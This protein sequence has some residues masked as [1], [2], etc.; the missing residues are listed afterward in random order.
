MHTSRQ[1]NEVELTDIRQL[2]EPLH[3]I[4][5][6]YLLITHTL[7]IILIQTLHIKVQLSLNYANIGG[8]NKSQSRLN[9]VTL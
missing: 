1:Q 4:H 5:I 7:L 6:W 2:A 9:L 8:Q 3:I